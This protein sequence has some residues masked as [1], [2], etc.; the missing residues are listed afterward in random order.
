VNDRIGI[1][2]TALDRDAGR[3]NAGPSMKGLPTSRSL[4]QSSPSEC[5]PL[6]VALMASVSATDKGH[7]EFMMAAI[8][9][10]IFRTCL[11]ECQTL[12]YF[13]SGA[14]VQMLDAAWWETGVV[15]VIR[16]TRG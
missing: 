7:G 1:E 9:F 11:D 16:R 8:T 12:T 15:L 13:T 10:R 4:D 2:P 3:R 6:D 5:P 14:V